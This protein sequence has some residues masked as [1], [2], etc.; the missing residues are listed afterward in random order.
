MADESGLALADLALAPF[1]PRAPWWGGDLQTLHNYLLR[2]RL[3][4]V[5]APERLVLPLADGSGDHLTAALNRPATPLA[6][7]PLVILIHGLTGDEDS[8]YMRRSA[9]SLLSAGYR[10]LRLNLRG[11]GPSRALSRF[12]YHAGRTADLDM[13]LAALPPEL[14]TNGAAAVGYSLGGNVLLKFLG[15]RGRAQPLRAAVSVS[16]PIDLAATARRMQ[17]WRNSG[18]QAYLMLEMRAEA[19]APKSEISEREKSAVLAA[20]SI[21]DFDHNFTAPRNGFT[22]ADDYYEKNSGRKFLGA[23][24]VPTL[25]IH[26][27]DDPWVPAEPY[28]AYDWTS[29]RAL[30]PV[31][32]ATGG[33]VGFHGADRRACWHDLTVRAFLGAVFSRT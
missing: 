18:Y 25:V 3:P 29:N 28:L 7:A 15:E 6:R 27:H 30:L 1:A 23:I 26:A 32:C 16:A 17:R 20:R 21:H 8:T 4:G 11:A 2:F 12:Q 10:V 14:L 22:G 24:K 13:A 31:L 33:H 19:L 9:A 5:A